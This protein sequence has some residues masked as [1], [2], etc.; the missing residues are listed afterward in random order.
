MY[1]GPYYS[2]TPSIGVVVAFDDLLGV[3]HRA[4]AAADSKQSRVQSLFEEDQKHSKRETGYRVQYFRVGWH[5]W[6]STVLGFNV[7]AA[8]PEALPLC[9]YSGSALGKVSVPQLYF[10]LLSNVPPRK[11]LL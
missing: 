5:M 1:S 3:F 4:W 7:V 9:L 2:I 6:Y 10:E 11:A 8:R